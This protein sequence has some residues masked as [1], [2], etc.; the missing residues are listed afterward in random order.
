MEAGSR[1]ILLG[2]VSA[3][4]LVGKGFEVGAVLKPA[5]IDPAPSAAVASTA[6][7]DESLAARITM[8]EAARRSSAMNAERRGVVRDADS[9]D[10]R[11]PSRT[12]NGPA[13]RSK[14]TGE[15]ALAVFTKKSAG[16]TLLSSRAKKAGSFR[17]KSYCK[18]PST[19]NY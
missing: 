14:W 2:I 13:A 8:S 7:H 18:V 11:L 4:I 17:G 16:V 12:P 9:E 6:Q 19:S 10:R 5:T 3:F 1:T 15:P